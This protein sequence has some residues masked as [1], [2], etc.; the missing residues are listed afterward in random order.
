MLFNQ[1]EKGLTVGG[2]SDLSPDEA[3]L[4]L[5][6]RRRSRR[7]RR[8]VLPSLPPLTLETTQI[9]SHMQH[10][11]RSLTRGRQEDAHELLRL[12]LEALHHAGLHSIGC[13]TY[14]PKAAPSMRDRTVVERVFGGMLCSAV[15]CRSCGAVSKTHD[16]FEDLSLELQGGIQS[17][18]EAL[19]AFTR[20]ER[21][22]AA[23][24]EANKYRC[25]SCKQL[26]VAD[27][28]I[29]VSKVRR[30]R[31]QQ[32]HAALSFSLATGA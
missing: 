29:M 3:R 23:N 13:P 11:A 1:I 5:S 24:D 18:D 19:A 6:R 32:H 2:A 4:K 15:S 17:L 20:T 21:L 10:F 14:G 22:G 26:T 25:E 12:T 28:R 8:L 31:V 30:L 27:K 16:T 7:R 9:L